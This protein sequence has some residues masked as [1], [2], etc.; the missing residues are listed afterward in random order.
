M[1]ARGIAYDTGFIY[2]G[3]VSRDR[4][5]PGVVRRELAIIR[6]DL[7]CNAVQVVGGPM[8][9]GSWRGERLGACTAVSVASA[10]LLRWSAIDAATRAVGLATRS[11]S[12][13]R[14]A[15]LGTSDLHPSNN[16]PPW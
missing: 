15:A 5:D 14:L 7:H 13:E 8:I 10:L 2:K 16:R 9:T 11:P 1:R 12:S 4:F 6:D 3:S